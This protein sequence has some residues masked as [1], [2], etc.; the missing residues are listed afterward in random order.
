VGCRPFLPKEAKRQPIP[1]LIGDRALPQEK[2]GVPWETLHRT[3]VIPVRPTLT[4]TPAAKS[5]AGHDSTALAGSLSQL[6]RH[7]TPAGRIYRP[8]APVSFR[9]EEARRVAVAASSSST[10]WRRVS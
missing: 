8:V 6:K 3:S 1:L 7:Y 10:A 4:L 2:A 9:C 5:A